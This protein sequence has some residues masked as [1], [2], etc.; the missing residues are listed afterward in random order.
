MF[1]W[2]FGT[3]YV[4]EAVNNSLYEEQDMSDFFG[5]YAGRNQGLYGVDSNSTETNTSVSAPTAS[6]PSSAAG[7]ATTT[8]TTTTSWFETFCALW[9]RKVASDQE[10]Q[11]KGLDALETKKNSADVS[12]RLQ[13]GEFA[14]QFVAEANR[15]GKEIIYER[16]LQ[17]FQRKHK[18]ISG[19]GIAGGLKFCINGIF[20]KFAL[21]DQKLYGSDENAMKAAGHEMMGLQVGEKQVKNFLQFFFSLTKRELLAF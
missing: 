7:A 5:F 2:N 15:I 16:S 20:F 9:L 18:P 13:I 10:T 14:A 4:E 19:A 8:T 21:D 12:I 1:G 17:E 3:M 6:S 11:V